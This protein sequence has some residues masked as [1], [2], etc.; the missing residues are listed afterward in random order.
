M[1]SAT[2]FQL[3]EALARRL[4]S[5]D[6]IFGGIQLIMCGDFFQLP[7]VE[8]VKNKSSSSSKLFCFES[9]AWRKCVRPEHQ[10]ELT[11]I[12]RQSN[13]EFCIALNEI[14]KGVCTEKVKRMLRVVS[15]PI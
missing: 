8:I 12:F 2:V 11:K 3:L 5:T 7:P 9:E 1:L 15:M 14:R 10:F 4:R 13:T 6:K